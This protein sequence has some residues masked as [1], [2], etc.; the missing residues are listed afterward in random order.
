M[1]YH[2]TLD[3]RPPFKLEDFAIH[4]NEDLQKGAAL[5]YDGCHWRLMNLGEIA[6]DLPELIEQLEHLKEEI[7]Q[8][9]QDAKDRAD[10]AYNKAEAVAQA[11]PEY[12][13]YIYV[14]MDGDT[15]T[16]VYDD[17]ITAD[18]DVILTRISWSPSWII[19]TYVNTWSVEVRSSEDETWTVRLRISKPWTL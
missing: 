11:N 4:C 17:F 8:E 6:E 2:I 5:V 12:L 14:T 9:V 13:K 15:S 1:A 18:S 7:D 3:N 19:E 16:T 10:E